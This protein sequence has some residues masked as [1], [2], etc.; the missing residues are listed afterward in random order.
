MIDYSGELQLYVCMSVSTP[1]LVSSAPSRKHSMRPDVY[2]Q[3]KVNGGRVVSRV[4]N[5][6]TYLGAGPS[7]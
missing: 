5:S 7:R 3:S 2:A 4:I 6:G 1:G